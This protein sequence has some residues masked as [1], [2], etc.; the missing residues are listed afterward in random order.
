[1]VMDGGM[2][3]SEYWITPRRQLE[4]HKAALVR[5]EERIEKRSKRRGRR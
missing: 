2:T 3:W 4:A 5:R 1:M